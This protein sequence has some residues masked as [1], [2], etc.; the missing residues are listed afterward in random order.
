MEPAA[1]ILIG[2]SVAALVVVVVRRVMRHRFASHGLAFGNRLV[3]EVT[4]IATGVLLMFL[5]VLFGQQLLA[6]KEPPRGQLFS[7]GVG[8]VPPGKPLPNRG[9]VSSLGAEFTS[10]DEPVN[11]TVVLAGTAEYFEDQRSELRTERA[12]TVAVPSEG[13][14][15]LRLGYGTDYF[16]LYDPF[17]VK[18]RRDLDVQWSAQE[19][20]KHRAVTSITGRMTDWQAHLVPLIARFKADWLLPRGLGTCYLKLPHMA[21]GHTLIAAE[22]ALG[23]SEATSGALVERFPNIGT[24]TSDDR[25]TIFVSYDGPSRAI[26]QGVSVVKPGKNDVIGS[27]PETEIVTA[28]LPALLCA[29]EQPRTGGFGESRAE[30]VFGP[31][32]G[33]AI[34]NRSFRREAHSTTCGGVFTLAE[35]GAPARRDFVL[36]MIGA[37][38]SIGAALVLEVALDIQ[39]RRFEQTARA[40][41][42]ASNEH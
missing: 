9:F 30:L 16:D 13:V 11:V 40:S 1:P 14:T 2:A 25:E 29:A 8:I 21:G 33:V 34:R 19:P 10:C 23:R 31:E 28:G 17:T 18:P 5:T 24:W 26:R 36:L 39:R 3:T 22:D 37:A 32:G 4:F 20:R 6:V 7:V 12:V 27:Q 38:F 42:L 35:T 15:D 41:S